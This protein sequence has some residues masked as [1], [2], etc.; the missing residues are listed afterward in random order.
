MHTSKDTRWA[1]WLAPLILLGAV[2]GLWFLLGDPEPESPTR[3]PVVPSFITESAESRE[4]SVQ[5]TASD[6]RVPAG[7]EASLEAAPL[8]GLR[9][10]V[11]DVRD[12][13]E[14][15][16]ARILVTLA[17][18]YEDHEITTTTDDGGRFSFSL[19]TFPRVVTMLQVRVGEAE[20][21]RGATEYLAFKGRDAAY[22]ELELRR[23]ALATLEGIV[24]DDEGQGLPGA[25]ISLERKGSPTPAEVVSGQDGRFSID[26]TRGL[27][28]VPRVTL[29]GY[30]TLHTNRLE[31]RER[32]GWHPLRLVMSPTARLSIE[33]R[34]G[35]GN[36]VPDARVSI[37]IAPS[38]KLGA[39]AG[40][41]WGDGYGVD[42][43]PQTGFSDFARDLRRHTGVDGAVRFDQTWSGRRLE[44]R[45]PDG[46]RY[47]HVDAFDRLVS[48]DCAE[49]QPLILSP[50]ADHRVELRMGAWIHVEGKVTD[51]SGSARSGIHV[52]VSSSSPVGNV[53]RR[54][55][56]QTDGEGRYACEVLD[57][58]LGDLV[59]VRA[60]DGKPKGWNAS[61][62]ENHA[63][64]AADPRDAI[65]GSL[66]IDLVLQ[67]TL[68]LAGRVL[69]EEGEAVSARVEAFREST[70]PDTDPRSVNAGSAHCEEGGAFRIGGLEAGSYE[71]RVRERLPGVRSMHVFSGLAAGT[72][73]LELRITTPANVSIRIRAEAEGL[74]LTSCVVMIGQLDPNTGGR[75]TATA[76]IE[77]TDISRWPLKAPL[78][79]TTAGDQGLL[80]WVP[81]PPAYE[82]P[83]VRPGCYRIGIEAR[84]S[85][86]RLLYPMAS[87]PLEFGPGRYELVAHLRRGGS[88]SGRVV[89]GSSSEALAVAL[90]GEHGVL[91]PLFPDGS[92]GIDIVPIDAKGRFQV[93]LAPTGEFS[94]IVG[95]A[96]ELRAGD[97]RVK[98]PLSIKPGENEPLEIELDR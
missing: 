27:R 64:M 40:L 50:G 97:P 93:E 79:I 87:G 43:R 68:F 94:L 72:G 48:D 57:L 67:P 85:E 38:E 31:A 18:P 11:L 44:V 53:R 80:L 35:E 21:L 76:S 66:V 88:I 60:H 74:E 19:D 14:T 63:T 24:V 4:V 75:E 15:P 73:D 83:R 92:N 78:W 90:V 52:Q 61:S 59:L 17:A 8:P 12:G 33:L 46:S 70:V 58:E 6:Q 30:V 1:L 39:G 56:A 91:L 32:G 26:E 89:G 45:G 54:C 25:R 95:S 81:E 98:L 77:L 49:A 71:L 36:P 22:D 47:A 2:I 86:K 13:E 65:D 96:S 82:W 23:L 62:I 5:E 84:D 3:G 28:G 10:T 29:P 69:D 20:M 9:G 51:S 55:R 42:R 7:V 16:A 34:D 37:A 41:L